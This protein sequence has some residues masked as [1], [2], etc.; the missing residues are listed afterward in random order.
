MSELQARVPPSGAGPGDTGPDLSDGSGGATQAEEQIQHVASEWGFYQTAESETQA[1][2]PA[3]QQSYEYVGPDIDG[4]KYRIVT[5]K[6][7]SEE[8][9]RMKVLYPHSMV[10]ESILKDESLGKY[11]GEVVAKLQVR[12]SPKD[13]VQLLDVFSRTLNN[14][15]Q[16][17]RF[18]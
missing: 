14:V 4:K 2:E 13:I 18:A 15:D 12:R 9:A 3:L 17:K 6:E 7:Y 10:R 16:I 1:E 5:N 11:F 8:E